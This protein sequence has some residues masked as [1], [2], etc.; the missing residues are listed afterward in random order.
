MYAAED[1]RDAEIDAGARRSAADLAEDV[2]LTAE[3]LAPEIAKIGPGHAGLTVERTPGGV[4]D[5]RRARALHAP[6]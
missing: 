4:P 3:R 5:P 1:A 6:A 2:R